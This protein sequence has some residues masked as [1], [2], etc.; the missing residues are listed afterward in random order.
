MRLKKIAII[1]LGYVGLPLAV[2][3]GKKRKVVGYDIDKKRIYEIK[4]GF[5]RTN[6]VL[7][8]DLIA[9][10][11]LNLTSEIEKIKDCEIYIITVPT[12]VNKTLKPDLKFLIKASKLVG[13]II[14]KNCTPRCRK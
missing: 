10:R 8:K 9:A 1:G 6:E 11:Y 4:R 14:K 2:E 13:S 12:P 5:D 7:K 3:F